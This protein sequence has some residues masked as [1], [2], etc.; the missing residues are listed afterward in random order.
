MTPSEALDKLWPRLR[1]GLPA[2]YTPEYLDAFLARNRAALEELV[3]SML[4]MK[5]VKRGEPPRDTLEFQTYGELASRQQARD[6]EAD[7]V[8]LGRV[9]ARLGKLLAKWKD[10][11]ARAYQAMQRFGEIRAHAMLLRRDGHNAVPLLLSRPAL[12]LVRGGHVLAVV[13]DTRKF[14]FPDRTDPADR[15]LITRAIETSGAQ[16]DKLRA[17]LAEPT[18]EAAL[19]AYLTALWDRARR[20]L[21]RV[22][23]QPIRAG[24]VP[25]DLRDRKSRT[26]A[27]VRAIRLLHDKRPEEMT[28]EDLLA[29]AEYSGSGGLSIEAM[30]KA[31]PEELLPETFGLIHEYYTPQ[32]I[33]DAIATTLC[34]ILPELAGHDGIIRALEPSAGIGR[35]IR[36]FTPQQCLALVAQAGPNGNAP[37]LGAIR[38]YLQGGNIPA[39]CKGL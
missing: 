32:V 13:G 14:V 26:A 1:T 11:E 9:I 23:V 2:K 19:R 10:D 16:L 33:A 27:N 7:E 15:A 38:P 28:A 31:V 34:P 25:P 37:E 18:A 6:A 3:A 8:V 17:G 4:A 21:S 30:K 22:D 12:V 36:A 24:E 35:L 5:R 29:L 20:G 39:I